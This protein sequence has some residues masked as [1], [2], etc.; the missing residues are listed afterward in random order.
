MLQSPVVP[1]VPPRDVVPPW[2]L[3]G[4]STSRI[5]TANQG[6]AE[7]TTRRQPRRSAG[8]PHSQRTFCRPVTFTRRATFRIESSSNPGFHPPPGPAFSI[9]D[10]TSGWACP[11]RRQ[12]GPLSR[13]A[14]RPACVSCLPGWRSPSSKPR[15]TMVRVRHGKM[16][17]EFVHLK[18]RRVRE[19]RPG[20]ARPYPSDGY[21]LS[22]SMV[23]VTSAS[24][25]HLA[26]SNFQLCVLSKRS[27]SHGD[28]SPTRIPAG[29]EAKPVPAQPPVPEFDQ[30]LTLPLRKGPA[31]ALRRHA[32]LFNG[33]AAGIN[34]NRICF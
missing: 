27:F 9:L 11:A 31:A 30:R 15:R 32:P 26:P 1:C 18:A 16:D 7:E 13:N 22:G 24:T 25:S 33:A 4:M 12:I 10:V 14:A 23:P 17:G 3:Q 34:A 20:W 6:L 5:K 29:W 28:S 2:K 8:G 21:C 19:R